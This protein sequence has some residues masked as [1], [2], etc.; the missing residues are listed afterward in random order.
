MSRSQ[1][2]AALSNAHAYMQDAVRA[3]LDLPGERAQV[4]GLIR[5]VEFYLQTEAHTRS[6]R[7]G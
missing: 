5:A 2:L 1:A 3:A 4:D 7:F 6:D